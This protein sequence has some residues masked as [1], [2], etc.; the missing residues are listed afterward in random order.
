MKSQFNKQKTKFIMGS[1]RVN[2]LAKIFAQITEH[3]TVCFLGRSN[4]GKSS[5]LNALFGNNSARV[6]KTPGKTREINVFKYSIKS[7]EENFYCFDLPGY[8]HAQVSKE[9]KRI[10]DAMIPQFLSILPEDTLMINIQ[11]ARHPLQKGDV[12]LLD[13]ISAHLF[14]VLLC[15]NKVDKLRTQKEKA[16][17]KKE[18]K[19]IQSLYPVINQVIEFSAEKKSGIELLEN[20]IINAVNPED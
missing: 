1:P 19:R 5:T 6:S 14:N 4:V 11:D 3:P 16:G 7:C 20:I 18:A 13:Y 2:D 9:Q 17:L 10:W 8:G 15:F 12:A